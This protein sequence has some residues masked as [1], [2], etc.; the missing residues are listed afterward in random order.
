MKVL[1]FGGQKS[2]KS[3]AAASKALSI[4]TSKP[5]YVAT[6]DNSYQDSEMHTRVRKHVVE[7]QSHFETI[8]ASH[9]LREVIQ[10][11]ETYL[12]DC[13]SM[14]IFNNLERDEAE[15]LSELAFI[16]AS[17]CN[18]IFVLNDVS[19]GIIPIDEESRRFVDL[20]GIIG[21]F[22]ASHCEEVYRVSFGIEERIK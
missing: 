8:E 14:W 11:G 6:Y 15:L 5:Y 7:R 18:I 21:Q 20:S 4:A 17:D 16:L 12:V 2:G 10:M 3:N 1:Y 9:H 22:V 13:L 19:C